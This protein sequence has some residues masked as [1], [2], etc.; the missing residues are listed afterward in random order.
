MI[1]YYL[2]SENAAEKLA[3]CANSLL[4]ETL[5]DPPPA[6]I[7][8]HTKENIR[9]ICSLKD[10]INSRFAILSA[11]SLSLFNDGIEM[12]EVFA[13]IFRAIKA[14]EKFPIRLPVSWCEYHYKSLLSFFAVKDS[15]VY[16]RWIVEVNA[17]QRALIFHELTSSEKILTLETFKTP[18]TPNFRTCFDEIITSHRSEYNVSINDFKGVVD[19]DSIGSVAISAM[20]TYEEWLPLLHSR[21]NDVLEL[22]QNTS[23]S[24]VG[25][26]GSGKTLTL[27][28]RALQEIKSAEKEGRSVR[29]LFA[30]HSWAM[31]ERIDDTIIALNAGQP[32]NGITVYPLLQILNDI[33]GG[34]MLQGLKL[35]GADSTE[36]RNLQVSYLEESLHSISEIDKEIIR[37][38][39][40]S[41]Y[42]EK[43]LQGETAEK[44]ELI[45][46]I[47]E[48]INGILL[49][50]NIMPGDRRKEDEY[51]SR[52][53]GD[54]LPPFEFRGDRCLVLLIYKKFLYRLIE[55]QYITTDQLVSDATKI[56]ETFSW[57]LKRESEG[58][59]IIVVD[60]LQLFDAQERFSLSLLSSSLDTTT[61]ITA[62]DPSQ[63]LFSNI[64]PNW[65]NGI[66]S[67]RSDRK[68]IRLNK[69]VRFTPSILQLI[70]K[71]Y[72]AFPL[73][74]EKLEIDEE[75]NP[76]TDKPFIALEASPEAAIEKS[77]SIVS[78]LSGQLDPE[79]R[80]AVITL[81][82]SLDEVI[83]KM[84]NKGIQNITR[85]S[86]L[87][88]VEKLTYS[89]R[90]IVV[91]E[92]Q[93]LGGTQFTH[94]LIVA[95]EGTTA[96][97]AFAKIRELTALYVAASRASRWLR[98]VISGEIHQELKNAIKDG[99]AL[100]PNYE[101]SY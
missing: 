99:I 71:L 45:E 34:S 101:I 89:K 22:P 1:K 55:R 80:L 87:D 7:Y 52:Y 56:L 60:E 94:V 100:C 33:L 70:Y 75:I 46:N 66:P 47:Y 54:D 78:E 25:P 6:E 39:K 8:S 72:S 41:S 26:A 11:S 12:S 95:P 76:N 83:L 17:Q 5:C 2:V 73:N 79:S 3:L 62:E 81:N 77:C 69:S 98:I 15:T 14:S 61:F 68:S 85:I 18:K 63:G 28:L 9:Y 53:R 44:N 10:D 59:D 35:L 16:Y 91:G 58:Y 90:T 82:N 50:E 37:T 29:V 21:Q 36:G 48:E 13:R 86:G 38:Q 40:I 42:I 97:S 23:V 92:W 49:A 67:Y 30:T 96:S 43:A 31:A 32:V 27:C 19:F 57:G 4:V 74:A 20:K 88:D 51:L 93:Y 64:M 84:K 24:I 65:R